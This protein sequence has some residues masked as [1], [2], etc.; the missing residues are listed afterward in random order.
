MEDMHEVKR[1]DSRLSWKGD[2]MAQETSKEQKV[3]VQQQD[4]QPGIE[5]EMIPKPREDDEKYRG[6][7]KLTVESILPAG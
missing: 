5:S 1:S 3:P 4:R 7:G 6:S 2:N